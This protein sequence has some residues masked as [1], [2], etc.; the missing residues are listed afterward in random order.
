MSTWHHS[1]E[2]KPENGPV[3]FESL[4][5]GA[6]NPAVA[7][8]EDPNDGFASVADLPNPNKSKGI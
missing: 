6:P 4:G 8:V 5:G 1:V 2:H 7:E 3:G